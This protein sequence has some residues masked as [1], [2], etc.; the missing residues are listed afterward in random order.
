MAIVGFD[1][2]PLARFLVPP[3]TTV[4]L[5][6]YELGTRAADML[7]RTIQDEEVAEKQILLRTQLMIRESCGGQAH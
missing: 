6:A 1:D 3:L 7:I 5:P 4:R 2:I